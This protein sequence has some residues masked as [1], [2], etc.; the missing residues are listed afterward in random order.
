MF[1]PDPGSWFLPI[2]DPGSRIP[3]PGS[4]NSNKRDG[5]KKIFVITFYV[6]TNFTILQ[7]ILFLKC[8]RKNLGQFSKNYR[9]FYPKIVN[10][11]SKIRVWDPGS[12]KTYSGSQI[13]GSKRHRILD[14][15]PQHCKKQKDPTDP[16]ANP[17][18]QHWHFGVKAYT[19]VDNGKYW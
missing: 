1:I 9:T 8:W 15:D 14:T 13:Q 5:W 6:A 18:P 12:G 17:D 3:D 2:T 11:L 16:D 19:Y 10:K 7:I 4:K